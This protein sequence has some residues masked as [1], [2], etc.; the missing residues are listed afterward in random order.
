MI[1]GLEHSVF[2]QRESVDEKKKWKWTFLGPRRGFDN[3]SNTCSDPGHLWV[4][5][6]YYW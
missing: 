6:F 3:E 4:L 1:Q 2:E 5:A